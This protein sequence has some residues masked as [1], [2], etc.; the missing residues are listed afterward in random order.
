MHFFVI[1][2]CDCFMWSFYSSFCSS[3]KFIAIIF[4]YFNTTWIYEF[5]KNCPRRGVFHNVNLSNLENVLLRNL[6]TDRAWEFIF[7]LSMGTNVNFFPLNANHGGA[8]VG[9]MHVPDCPK[10]LYSGWVFCEWDLFKKKFD[11]CSKLTIKTPERHHLPC[12]GIFIANFEHI[13]HLFLVFFLCWPWT[14]IC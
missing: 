7:R 11:I 4:F 10:K 1:P 13:T 14:V 5:L 12:P 6:I 9:L 3:H 8:F 2:L